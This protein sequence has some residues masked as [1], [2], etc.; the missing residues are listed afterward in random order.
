MLPL[1]LFAVQNFRM[2][3]VATVLIYGALAVGTF[4]LTL[5]LQQVAGYGATLAGLAL[6]PVV[7][8]GILLSSFFGSLAGRYG[9]RLFMSVGPML[10]GLGYLLL[11]RVDATGDYWGTVFPGLVVFGLGLAITV[12]PLTAAILGSIAPQRAGIASAVNKA[13]SRVAGLVAVAA[14]SLVTGVELDVAGF[15]RAIFAA[16]VLLIAGGI[17]LATGIRNPLPSG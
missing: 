15:H 14:V 1:G 3:N 5:F 13:V 7:I 9:P 16:A 10:G 11:I 2:A 17:D 4:V 12:A 8:L 6:L